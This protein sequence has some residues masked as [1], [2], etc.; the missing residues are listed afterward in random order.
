M[1]SSAQPELVVDQAPFAAAAWARSSTMERGSR[2]AIDDS[3]VELRRTRH[4]A[5][6]PTATRGWRQATRPPKLDAGAVHLWTV[7]LD[8]DA[9][10]RAL[11]ARLSDEEQALAQ[12]LRLGRVRRRFVV[13]RVVLRE[14]L[15]EYTSTAPGELRFA[16]N[17]NGKPRLASPSDGGVEFNVS[18]SGRLALIAVSRAGRVG[19]DI[20]TLERRVGGV[21][22]SRAFSDGER[23]RITRL[24]VQDRTRAALEHW[25]AKEAYLKAIGTGLRALPPPVALPLPVPGASAPLTVIPEALPEGLVLARVIVRGY[26]GGVAFEPEVARLCCLSYTP[27]PPRRRLLLSRAPPR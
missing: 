17:S 24:P 2:E 27:P 13:T 9:E 16:H 26:V 15:G 4:E 25:T 1:R 10:R 8:A 22:G 5:G 11:A 6:G 19:V 23:A 12:R 14:L 20:E 21:L 7:A 3:A 18:H